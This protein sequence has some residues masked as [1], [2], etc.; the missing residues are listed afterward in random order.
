MAAIVAVLRERFDEDWFRNPRAAEPLR[1][2]ASRGLGLS[3]EAW[4]AELGATA[5]LAIAAIVE[6]AR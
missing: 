1:A 5:P 4:T 2:A 3:I 6:A